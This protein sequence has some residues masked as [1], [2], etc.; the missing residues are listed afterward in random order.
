MWKRWGQTPWLGTMPLG[1][2]P[3]PIK[4][5]LSSS[6]NTPPCEGSLS[7]FRISPWSWVS[8]IHVPGGFFWYDL[9][10]LLLRWSEGAEVVGVPRT[11]VRSRMHHCFAMLDWMV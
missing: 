9:F 1:V 3:L 4:G 5:T 8:E 7:P 10:L 2:P 11:C 6:H